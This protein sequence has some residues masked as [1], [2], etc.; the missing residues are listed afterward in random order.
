MP[1]IPCPH[2]GRSISDQSKR[3]LYCAK[4]LAG[5]GGGEA[6][7]RAQMLSAMYK[8][9][10]GLPVT[11]K[12]SRLEQLRDEPFAVRLLAGIAMIPGLLIWPPWVIRGWKTIFRP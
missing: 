7:K 3:C 11:P 8:A 10:V 6:E 1:N 12:R 9:G 4:P 2:C 5:D